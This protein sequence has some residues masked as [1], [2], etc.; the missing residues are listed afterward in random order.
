MDINHE[1][2]RAAS[3]EVPFVKCI[4]D[5]SV[6]SM[7]YENMRSSEVPGD[8]SEKHTENV[9]KWMSNIASYRLII[10]AVIMALELQ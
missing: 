4:P 7:M 1:P 8:V 10:Q 3:I 9:F 2:S 5:A 6:K